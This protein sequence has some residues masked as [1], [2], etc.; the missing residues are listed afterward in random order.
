MHRPCCILCGDRPLIWAH[1]TL[2]D[3]AHA[4]ITF[5]YSLCSSCLDDE[6]APAR[7]ECAYLVRIGA[8]PQ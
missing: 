2:E 6:D 3:G 5:H 1:Y 7:A 4:G 8:T